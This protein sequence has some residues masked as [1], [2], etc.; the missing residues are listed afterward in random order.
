M[1]SSSKILTVSYGTF[2]CTLEGFDDSFETMKAIAEY[3]RDLAADDR[4]FGA[5]PPTPDA[6]TLA[7]I[8]EREIA[9]RVEAHESAGG[10]VLRAGD[11]GT[12]APRAAA[13]AA[14]S[15][16]AEQPQAPAEEA[17][18]P[19]PPE[20]RIGDEPAPTPEVTPQADTAAEPETGAEPEP[21][22]AGE[23]L[24]AAPTAQPEP[25]TPT[26]TEEAA[27][28]P[29]PAEEP[30]TATA[31]SEAPTADL[32]EPEPEAA[33]QAADAAPAPVTEAPEGGPAAEAEEPAEALEP[34]AEEE[35]AAAMPTEPEEPA[36][37]EAPEAEEPGAATD[38]TEAPMADLVEPEAARDA[39][40]APPAPV[41]E[42]PETGPAAEAEEPVEPEEV[43]EAEERE[44]APTPEPA[45]PAEPEAP[46]AKEP[47]GPTEAAAEAEEPITAAAPAGAAPEAGEPASEEEPESVA[48]KLRRIRAVVA[49]AEP[50]A[51]D[52]DESYAE[53]DFTPDFLAGPP[54]S[55]D[56]P[57]GEEAEEA[58]HP[59]AGSAE[60]S[61]PA[62]EAGTEEFEEEDE[63][64]APADAAQDTLAELLADAMPEPAP[65]S[66]EEKT[67]H[68]SEDAE[69]AEPAQTS[70]RVVRMKR[71]QF[72]AAVAEGYIQAEIEETETAGNLFSEADIEDAETPEGS[73]LS[74]EDEAE[75]QRELAE[76]EAELGLEEETG[77]AP[78]TAEE[79]ETRLLHPEEMTDAQAPDQE[80]PEARSGIDKLDQAG[81][82]A[83]LARIFDET[84]NQLER[85]ESSERRSA[86]QRLRAA[87]AATRAEKDAGTELKKDVDE[88]A[89]RSDLQEVVRP[90]RTRVADGERS[91]RPE[92]ARPAPLKLVAEQRIDMPHEPVRPRRVSTADRMQPQAR[93]EEPGGFQ[94]F[95]AEMGATN[96]PDLLEAAAAYLSD[97]EGRPQFSRPMLMSKLKEVKQD[98]FSR[99]DGLRS[100]GQL[101]RQGKLQKLKG[102][103]FSITDET[104]YRTD[105]RSV[106]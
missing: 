19:A 81:P 97:V 11:G 53:A 13:P 76:V 72:E 49:R 48:A 38:V 37:P 75:L 25:E 77:S 104:E 32:V 94:D 41:T 63:T 59:E 82:G 1:I 105:A 69:T 30:G 68:A 28:T 87:V 15:E 26:E 102:G 20:A 84:D 5:E 86:I 2:S 43:R 29:E 60:E 91:Q 61:A 73:T 55:F 67:A 18:E 98:Q 44:S 56:A 9:R 106:G 54:V 78:D 85:P 66:A 51:E 88:A 99:E 103:R 93:P 83:E 90:R 100:F 95:V 62:P 34:A 23:S 50:P 65:G 33:P 4:Y 101:L 92:T 71:Q 31:A 10:I 6:E 64:A 35:T 7:R 45:E 8:A 74:A 21:A 96:L 79:A 22:A 80:M 40:E 3:F 57:A 27:E 17:A 24:P 46:A 14:E 12:P 39:A 36:A 70:A 52:Y 42:A 58:D 16:P 89:Y 47:A